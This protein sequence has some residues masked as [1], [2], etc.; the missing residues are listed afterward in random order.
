MQ[1][2]KKR[3]FRNAGRVC[4]FDVEAS[5]SGPFLDPITEVEYPMIQGS[6]LDHIPIGFVDCNPRSCWRNPDLWTESK[7]PLRNRFEV[8]F[9]AKNAGARFTHLERIVQ[10]KDSQSGQRV[11]IIHDAGRSY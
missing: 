9:L 5:R 2:A 7:R 4:P 10:R 8:R 11:Q 3:A 6:G 1:S